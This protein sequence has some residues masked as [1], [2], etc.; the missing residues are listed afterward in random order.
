MAAGAVL[1]GLL[2]AC[3]DVVAP[4]GQT[5]FLPGE[6]VFDHLDR[7]RIDSWSTELLPP[8]VRAAVAAPAETWRLDAPAEDW[9]RRREMTAQEAQLAALPGNPAFWS[10]NLSGLADAPPGRPSVVHRGQRL[11]ALDGEARIATLPGE[12]IWWDE[13][14]ATIFVL[15]A[16]AA[17]LFAVCEQAPGDTALLYG[18]VVDDRL[19][20]AAH[21]P[22]TAHGLEQRGTLGRVSRRALRLPA[23][24]RLVLSVPLARVDALS[25]AVGLPD[26][27]RRVEQGHLVEAPGCSDGVLVAVDVTAG[28]RTTRAWSM[29]LQP[30]EG[31]VEATVDLSPWAGQDVGLALV[32]EPGP[33]GDAA[34]DLVLF[35]DLRLLG[36][37]RRLPDRPHVILVDIDTLRADRIGCLGAAGDPTP[38]LDRWANRRATIFTDTTATAS[39]TL[40]STASMLTGLAVHQHGVDRFPRGLTEDSL[41][42]A[43]VLSRAG[44]DT[45][46]M[47]EGGFVMPT[48]GFDVGFDSYDYRTHRDPDWDRALEWVS[49]RRSEQ[50]FFLFLQTY[51]VH[52]P[53][54]PPV[55]VGDGAPGAYAGVLAGHPVS[56]ERVL[57][58]FNEGQLE[59]DEA[60][61]RYVTRAYDAGVARMDDELGGFLEGLS[62]QFSPD[63]VVI[64]VTSDHGE[65]LFEHGGLEHGRTLYD[66]VLRVPF[67][68]QLPGRRGGTRVREPTSTLDIVP[69]V[70]DA[71]GLPVPSGL[72]GRSLLRELPAY[73]GRVAAHRDG[74]RSIQFD[75]FK[76]IEPPPDRPD[77][78]PELF[79]LQADPGEQRNLI[80]RQPDKLRALRE[81]LR[82]FETDHPPAAVGAAQAGEMDDETRSTLKA[83]GYLGDV[84]R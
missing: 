8:D 7:V 54:A 49:E 17:V 81:R 51:M 22:A 30:G 57:A 45:L 5:A 56:W 12:Q 72:P 37:P 11:G 77:L 58:P 42:L 21:R 60:D 20:A 39:W 78:E 71:V 64:I 55:A 84:D 19:L 9:K 73:R 65:E 47:C 48:F 46:G 40:P 82:R 41:P 44:Y 74:R 83:L 28:G 33:A 76:L 36:K 24:G 59:L 63:D 66:E 35:A 69:T 61:R 50:P 53:Y 75:G 23:P 15:D 2:A 68:A 27:G 1:L 10:L 4:V 25:V 79:D 16:E 32:S 34:F 62:R 29:A 26:E 80:A 31:W 70:L 14:A 6:S 43:T 38:R 3:G 13:D 18:S 52:A 67:L